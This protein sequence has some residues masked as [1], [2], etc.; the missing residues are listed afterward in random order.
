MMLLDIHEPGE[1]PLPH[2]QDAEEAAVGIDLGTTNSLVAISHGGTPEIISDEMG[3]TLVPSVVAYLDGE[4]T[5]V[6]EAARRALLDDADRVVA[7]VKRLMGRGIEDMKGLAGQ[8]P[9][10]I[11][12]NEA[13][14]MVKLRVGG[15]VLSPVE[16]SAEILKALRARGEAALGKPVTRA[17]ITVPAYFDDAARTATRDAARLAG[18]EVLRLVNEPTAAA[19]AYGL[20]QGAEGLYAVFDLG[21][22]TFDVSLLKLQTGV[23][24]V[25]AT[26]GDAALGGDD[27]DHAIAEHFLAQRGHVALD[28]AEVKRALVT[29]RLAKECLTDRNTGSWVIEVGGEATEHHLDVATLEHLIGPLV[30]RTIAACA[31]V[32]RDADVSP[33]ELSGV[34]LVGGS[35]R[36]PLVRRRVAE[37]FGREPLS[38]IDPDQVVALGAALQAE[39]LTR[40]SD[41][42]LLDVVPLSLGMETMGG[43]VEKVI[44]RNTPMPVSRAQDFTTYQ[45]GQTAM[46]IHVVQG[47]RE[48]VHQNRSLARFELHGIPPMTAGAARIRV[49]FTVDADGLLTVSATEASTGIAQSVEVKPSYGLAEEDMARMLKE[50][51]ENAREDMTARLLTEAR[52]DAERLA[53]AVQA[54]LTTDGD[55]LDTAERAAVDASLAHLATMVA[56]V[57]RE[58]V[59]GAV[60]ALEQATQAF[61]ERRMDRGIRTALSGVAIGRLESKLG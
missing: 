47:E 61:A 33:T 49:N 27:F 44:P 46:A 55:L 43:L 38:N 60:E 23:F 15:R 2:S 24:Q 4:R 54:A 28:V 13:G 1:T 48:L 35:T 20:D 29:A 3:Q 39:A 21:G 59:L 58:A 6:G 16:V 8:L 51:W 17:V 52:V 19:L 12:P 26:G 5:L 10:D 41:T 25:L 30:E 31:D 11:V 53:I 9:Y 45:D 50:S 7:S 18:L 32:L 34:V 22:G 56:G 14:G 37:F 57:D 40:G 36:V 42:L